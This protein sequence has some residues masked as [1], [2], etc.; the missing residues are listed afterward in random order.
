M[1]KML[2]LVVG[3]GG[4]GITTMK[5]LNRMLASNPAMRTEMWKSTFYLAVD[6]E[7]AM[8]DSFKKD[9][10]KD[11]MGAIVPYSE[12]ICLSQ[13]VNILYQV[14]NPYFKKPFKGNPNY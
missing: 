13:D 10:E 4:S 3:C 9:I 5:S 2:T 8:L 12:T 14:V 1:A 11:M 7:M 6:T